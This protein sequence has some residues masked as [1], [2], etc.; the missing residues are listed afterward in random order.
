LFCYLIV[1]VHSHHSN[2]G[3]D[4]SPPLCREPSK[5]LESQKISRIDRI[6]LSDPF[7]LK[8]A[9][10]ANLDRSKA[11]QLSHDYYRDFCRSYPGK[12]G[13][14]AFA[15]PTSGANNRQGLVDAVDDENCVGI[16]TNSN[17][18]GKYPDDESFREIFEVA[19]DRKVPILIHP[20]FKSIGYEQLLQYHLLSILGRPTDVSLAAYRI[21][22]S[23]I[24]EEF[25]ATKLILSYGGGALTMLKL[26]LDNQCET[27]RHVA[28]EKFSS[29]L[30]K[31]PSKY[32]GS[33]YADTT[34]MSPEA[35]LNTLNVL[36]SDHVLLGTDFPP[37]SIPPRDY[38]K[39]IKRLKV[40][41]KT[42]AG[43]LGQNAKRLFKLRAS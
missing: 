12:F 9:D 37:G 18:D 36:G 25:P 26:R 1:D 38:V 30:T 14:F 4:T 20:N 43:I 29:T 2:P 8:Q 40:S 23:G 27:P 39:E 31:A 10:D 17:V 33:F 35:I 42:T 16:V 41:E 6:L 24:L 7:I 34:T 22:L 13:Y 19:S 15:Y 3:L 11:I 5:L 28:E 21:I 32:F